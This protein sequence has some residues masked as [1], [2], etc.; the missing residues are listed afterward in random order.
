M[1]HD[2]VRSTT[3]RRGSTSKRWSWILFTTSAEMW[4]APHE[5]TKVFLKPPSHQI[6]FSRLVWFLARSTAAIPPTLSDTLAATT[7]TAMRS[8]RVSTTPKVVRPET[9]FPA[10]Y[11]LVGLVTVEAPL[12][13]R[14]SMTPADGCASRP[15]R[16][17]TWS[18][19]RSQT[20][21][22]TPF[23]DQRT[24]YRWTVFQWG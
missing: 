2:Q 11:P 23:S 6:F 5:E 7:T 16:S 22:Q 1:S 24:W 19:S 15:S 18:R 8:P 10:S 21:S 13:L 14:A 17:R 3:H 9:F 20:R 4:C 12:T